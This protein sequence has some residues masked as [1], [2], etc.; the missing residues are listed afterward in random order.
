VAGPFG[1]AV[2][3]ADVKPAGKRRPPPHAPGV[4]AFTALVQTRAGGSR[5]PH[6]SRY[7]LD[8][9]GC[10]WPIQDIP[11]LRPPCAR[12]GRACRAG[13]KPP[14]LVLVLVLVLA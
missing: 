9:Q 1:G 14:V 12:A 10:E 5:L 6:G 7:R 8:E 11:R 4:H 13:P 3:A 2:R